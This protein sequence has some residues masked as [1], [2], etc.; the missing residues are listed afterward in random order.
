[1]RQNVRLL[2]KKSLHYANNLQY[3]HLRKKMRSNIREMF[4]AHRNIE[5]NETI[6]QLVDQ[7]WNH[8][9]TIKTL[10]MVDVESNG[11]FFELLSR[12]KK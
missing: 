4:V 6:D 8:L 9:K 7:G 2:A 3:L 10:E 12:K 11:K 1:M 5:D